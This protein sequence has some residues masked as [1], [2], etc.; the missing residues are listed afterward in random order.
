MCDGKFI[1]ALMSKE[2][3]FVKLQN[4]ISQIYQNPL[5]ESES[6]NAANAL[7]EYF[8]ILKG[9]SDKTRLQGRQGQEVD[10]SN[11]SNF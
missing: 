8:K 1:L 7:V 11:V 5:T 6:S 10:D 9:I 2:T 3:T 4:A